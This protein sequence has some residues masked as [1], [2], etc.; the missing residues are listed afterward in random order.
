MAKKRRTAAGRR[1]QTGMR[2]GNRAGRV[3]VIIMEVIL[4]AALGIGCYGVSILGT[5]E[6]EELAAGQIYTYTGGNHVTVKALGTPAAVE[7]E[8][9]TNEERAE[10]EETR[11]QVVQEASQPETEWAVETME[12]ASQE[13]FLAHQ[14]TVDGYW[15]ILIMGVDARLGQSLSGGDFRSDVII[16]CSINV[17]TKDIKLASIYRDTLLLKYGTD[18]YD[19]ANEMVFAAKGGSPS[20][21]LSTI[22][23]N[24][25]MNISDLII[26]NWAAVALAVNEL[27]GLWLNITQE[28]IDRHII[29]G[30]LTSVVDE[31]GIATVGGQFTAGGLQWCDGPKVVAYCRNRTTTGSDFARTDRQREVIQLLL[32]QAKQAPLNALFN[33]VRICFSNIYTTLSLDEMFS[34]AVD[35]AS[36]KIVGTTAFPENNVAVKALG[37][38]RDPVVARNLYDNVKSLHAYLFGYDYTPSDNVRIISDNIS[39]LSGY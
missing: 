36:Y 25:D 3:A 26:V 12:I 16:I 13:D 17:A 4:M 28:E 7:A 29:T 2:R 6:R 39:Y 18:T 11:T 38:V 14:Q 5:L 9:Q 27:G 32:E 35:V 22:N 1:Q 21:M 33:V 31:T 8:A 19:K 23:L 34:L 37:T 15:N 10:A 30:Y 24:L 20:V